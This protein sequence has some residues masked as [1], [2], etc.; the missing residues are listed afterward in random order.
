[1]LATLIRRYSKP[2][3]PYIL[4]VIVFQLAS[5]IAALYLP[6]LNAQIIDEGVS[7]GDTDFIWRTGAVMLLVAFLQVG[8]AIAGVYFGSKTAMAMGR[9][10]RRGVF[11]KVTSFSA[12][13]V[14]T[15][16]APTLITRGTNDVQQVQMLV[17][18]GLNFMISTPIMCIGGI[19]M[20]LREDINLS[21]LVWVSVP[22][23]IAV[24]GY[25]VV[26]LMPLFRSMQKKIDRINEV[27]R[28]QIIGIRV[29]RAFVREPYETERFGQANK[30]LTDVSLKIGAL[31]VLMFPAIGMILHLSTAAVLWFGGQRVDSG[32]MQ[33]GALTAFLQYLLQILMA[34]MM[35][36]FMAMMIPRASVCADRIGEVLDVEP[37]I[38]DPESPQTP[39]KL[40]GVVEYRNVTFAYP[41]A[42]APVLSNVSFTARPGE[43]V[44]IIG[45]TGAGKTSLLSLLPR[46]YDVADGEV[47]LDGVSVSKLD[48]AEITKRVALVPQRP[49]LF[50]GTIEHNLRFGKTE[51]TDEELW[52]ALQVAQGD[53][54]V[55]EK[56]NVLASRIAQGGTNVSGGQR[57]RL[58][59]ARALVTKPKVYLFDDSFSALDVA[60]DARLRAALKRTTADATVIIVAQRIS[61]IT[62]ADQILVLDNG[63]IVDR[64]THEELLETSPTYQEIVESQLSVEEVA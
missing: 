27:L 47:L 33:V 22:V 8:A 24:V 19:I 9:D 17:L 54:F 32:D 50:S 25:I 16:G 60:T 49:Y 12:K 31:F 57:Q 43:T 37:S 45:S 56:K 23:L 1:M 39:A 55:R 52:D 41:G 29:V 36:T 26:R 28:E 4:A 2:Y 14:N 44:A 5:T 42:E 51:A 35:G 6:S 10:L 53:G 64:G 62:E 18:M 11:R 34:V 21:W 3:M 40:E 30:E 15:F 20:A 13:D 58:C 7:R 48:R 59:I 38:H 63:R 46:L 61:T